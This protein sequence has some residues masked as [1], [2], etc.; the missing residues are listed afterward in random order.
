MKTFGSLTHKHGVI[1]DCNEKACQML[2]LPRSEIIGTNFFD[3]MRNEDKPR[4]LEMM[5]KHHEYL[6]D[7][8]FQHPNGG[9]VEVSVWPE[10]ASVSA[11]SNRTVYFR[12]KD[13]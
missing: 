10:A 8:K 1:A 6:I 2:K 12:V 13:T 9:E 3:Y 4:A 11:H 5:T 7:F